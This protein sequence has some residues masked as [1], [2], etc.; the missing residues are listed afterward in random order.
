[1]RKKSLNCLFDNIMWYLLYLLPLIVWLILLARNE[2][3]A[4]YTLSYVFENM[5]LGIINDNV[6]LTALNGVFAVG[7]VFPIFTA[8]NFILVYMTW[9]IAIMIVHLAVDFLVFIP[10]L[11]HKWLGCLTKDGDE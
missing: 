9:F 10:R 5:G 1:M 7:G 2:F 6:I 3:N 8:N 11:C 4:I